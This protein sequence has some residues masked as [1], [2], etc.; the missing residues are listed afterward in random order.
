MLGLFTQVGCSGAIVLLAAF[1]LSAVP[2]GETD[3]RGEGTYLLVNKNLIEACAI[4]VVLT[5]RTGT[6]AGLDRLWIRSPAERVSVH[7]ATV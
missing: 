1:Y 3:A 6:I 4:A 7:E 5:F 2:I